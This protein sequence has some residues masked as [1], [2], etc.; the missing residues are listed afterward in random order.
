MSSSFLTVRATITTLAPFSASWQATAFPIP[1]EPPVTT[2]VCRD[3]VSSWLGMDGLGTHPSLNG[4]F[5]LS[6][7]EHFQESVRDNATEKE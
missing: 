4:E 7:T 3:T 2:T 6:E 5:V 1:S